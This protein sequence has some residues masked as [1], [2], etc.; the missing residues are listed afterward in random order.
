[1]AYR[2]ALALNKKEDLNR[3]AAAFQKAGFEELIRISN[4]ME[5]VMACT[6][7]QIDILMIDME[8]PFMDCAKAVSYLV[9]HK[10]L[11]LVL[12]VADDWTPYLNEEK[13]AGI[14]IF[15]NR[16]ITSSKMIPGLMVNIARKE[17]LQKLEEEFEKEEEAFRKEKILNYT[18]H[19]LMDRLNCQEED[20][21]VY[22][23]KY[24]EAYETDI[25]E[26]AETFYSMM[27]TQ[28]KSKD[29]KE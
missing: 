18:L 11:K 4:T 24:A 21:K 16:P 1:M 25:H 8:L 6:F 29:R 5:L 3:A 22:L 9:E 19:L 7:Q 13:L 12:A 17:K 20:A 26:V 28:K 14:D 23:K 10:K 15:V 2:V 27:C